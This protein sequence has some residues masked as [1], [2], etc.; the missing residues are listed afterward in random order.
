MVP[1]ERAVCLPHN[2]PHGAMLCGQ[3]C[4]RGLAFVPFWF[5]YGQTVKGGG[6]SKGER[7]SRFGVFLFITLEM[8]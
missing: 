4:N 6:G 7:K 5:V 3:V 2:I 8:S 1:L